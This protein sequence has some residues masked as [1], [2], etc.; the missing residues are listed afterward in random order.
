M[1]WHCTLNALGE[2]LASLRTLRLLLAP[3]QQLPQQW[4]RPVTFSQL[5]RVDALSLPTW[6]SNI[7]LEVPW[8][9]LA[10]LTILH[11]E[12]PLSYPFGLPPY[13]SYSLLPD[14]DSADK[15]CAQKEQQSLEGLSLSPVPQQKRQQSYVI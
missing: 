3:K 4:D 11:S 13:S 2:D 14:S 8:C 1:D 15:H 12:I 7:T 10:L 9:I 5:S 6:P